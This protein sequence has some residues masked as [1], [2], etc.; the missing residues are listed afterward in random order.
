MDI[1]ISIFMKLFLQMRGENILFHLS[2]TFIFVIKLNIYIY[3]RSKSAWPQKPPT[4]RITISF[5]TSGSPTRYSV[6]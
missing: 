1:R 3:T 4:F 6:L 5:P 2:I